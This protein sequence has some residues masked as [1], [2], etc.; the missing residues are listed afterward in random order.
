[1]TPRAQD[2]CVCKKYRPLV[3][4]RDNKIGDIGKSLVADIR[5]IA[6]IQHRSC[7]KGKSLNESV[8]DSYRLISNYRL[9]AQF[10]YSSTVC[11][12]H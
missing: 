9:N 4:T 12:L 5:N 7:L 2:P 1:M 8:I 6:R 3:D 11:M 10:L